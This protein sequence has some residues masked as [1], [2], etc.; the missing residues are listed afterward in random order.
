M[1]SVGPATPRETISSQQTPPPV[2]SAVS[3]QAT[4]KSP[5]GHAALLYGVH[6]PPSPSTQQKLLLVVHDEPPQ[7][8]IP[9]SHG[10]PPAGG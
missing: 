1:H 8:T 10:A 6:A 3:S 7:A 5:L 4:V 2:Q 9:G